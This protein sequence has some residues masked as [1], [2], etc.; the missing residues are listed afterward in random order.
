[1][2]LHSSLL[3]EFPFLPISYNV[4]KTLHISGALQSH[5]GRSEIR[6]RLGKPRIVIEQTKN[7]NCISLTTY[8][9][10]CGAIE[11]GR[12]TTGRFRDRDE[13]ASPKYLYTLHLWSTSSRLSKSKLTWAFRYSITITIFRGQK[14]L[15]D[16]QD[17]KQHAGV[18]RIYSIEVNSF[19]S[20]RKQSMCGIIYVSPLPA[21]ESLC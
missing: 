6:R 19:S 9:N 18:Q 2:Q 11:E 13:F 16:D 21:L 8:V 10:P 5:Q 15:P 3:H 17:A 20:R 7:W 1:M 12:S 4:H 14:F